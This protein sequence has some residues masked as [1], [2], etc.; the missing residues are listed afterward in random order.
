M[1]RK[2]LCIVLLLWSTNTF[3]KPQLRIAAASSFRPALQKLVPMFEKKNSVK[4]NWR[5]ASSGALYNHI[6]NGAPYDLF[7]SADSTFPIR[8][9]QAGIADESSRITYALG[10]LAWWQPRT[11][12]AALNQPVH[13]QQAVALAKSKLAPY[14]RAAEQVIQYL[15]KKGFSFSK[16]VYGANISQTYQFID[17][18][19]AV[20]G[21]VAYSYLISAG[22]KQSFW[23]I[24]SHWYQPIEQQAIV[25]SNSNR[26]LSEKFL[27]FLQTPES[28]KII[29][30]TG[31][32]LP[33]SFNINNQATNMECGP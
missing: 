13:F 31:Y 14:G 15:E 33:P 19:N 27:S 16:K 12:N 10:V 24:P 5:A 22:I 23:I 9:A 26:C 2:I 6:V 21:F 32:S 28:R 8:L 11:E 7:L 25:I 3:S 4:V 29:S 20:G 30:E 17:S 18:G 1:L